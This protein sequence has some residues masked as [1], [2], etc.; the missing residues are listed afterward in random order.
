MPPLSA[1]G[2]T[3][4]M[5]AGEGGGC[6]RTKRSAPVRCGTFPQKPAVAR[7]VQYRRAVWQWAERGASFS[8]CL[9]LLTSLPFPALSCAK[10]WCSGDPSA[11][12]LLG[13]LLLLVAAL[14][15]G[16]A[17][18]EDYGRDA[19][20]EDAAPAGGSG[21]G[22]AGTMWI[23]N[24]KEVK[25]IL[26]PPN[27]IQCQCEEGVLACRDLEG[28]CACVGEALLCDG[29]YDC[30]QGEDEHHCNSG[31][32][33]PRGF[34]CPKTNK[35]IDK[36]LVCDSIDDCGDKSDER[37]CNLPKIN[38]NCS[39]D[40]QFT[41]AD[42]K[43]C[44]SKVWLCDG[45][46]DCQDKS[47]ETN[48]SS[49]C[50]PN[51]HSCGDGHCISSNW[52]CDGDPDCADESDELDCNKLTE[53]SCG[54]EQV[55]CAVEGRCLMQHYACDGENDCGDWSDEQNCGNET[56]LG[57]DFK[58]ESGRCIERKW[59]CDGAVDCLPDGEDEANCSLPLLE[60]GTAQ[61][62][63]CHPE[64]S[65]LCS[66]RCIPKEWWC[67][68]VK[69]C[70]DGSDEE[71]CNFTCP[72]E[73]FTC[74]PTACIPLQRRCDGHHD[75]LFGDDEKDCPQDSECPGLQCGS[76]ICNPAKHLCLCPP[77][78]TLAADNTTCEDVDECSVFRP[79]SQACENLPGSFNCS[80]I[81]GY[82]MLRPDHLTCKASQPPAY[83]IFS[84]R[85]E[86]RLISLNRSNY[87]SIAQGLQNAISIDYHYERRLI[88][89]SDVT[90]DVIM[91]AYMNGTGEKAI[92]RW[93]LRMPSGVSVDWINDHVYWLDGITMRI[94]VANLDGSSRRP[95]IWTNLQKPRGLLVHP[96][97]NL[98]I[99]TDWGSN[100]RIE[101]AFLDGSGR[102]VVIGEGLHWPNGITID[103]PTETLYWVD[104][105][106]HVIEAVHTDGSNRR[107]ILEGLRHPFAITIFEDTLYWTDWITR[108]I[109]KV[110]KR[111]GQGHSTLQGRLSF[112]MD[113]R[114]LHP[115]RQP[116]I[117]QSERHGC[118][119]RN[120]D[121]SHL[122]LSSRDSYSCYCPHGLI[123]L[124]DHR[125]CSERP[126]RTL[127]FAQRKN[128]RMISLQDILETNT[129]TSSLS[130]STNTS[131]MAQMRIDTVVP[132]NNVQAPVAL[133]PYTEEDMIFWTD[134]KAKTISR[135]HLNGS[136]HITVVRDGLEM[137]A[138]VAVDWVGH[139]LYWTD[140]GTSRIEVANLEGSMRC[141][142]IWRS[143][144]KPRD[145][146]VD[147]RAR[148]M[149]WTDW[150]KRAKI[151]RA[152]MDGE[153]RRVLVDTNLKWPNGLAIDHARQLLYWLDAS[154]KS[155]EM[156]ALDGSQR[157]ALISG[158]LE[159]PFGLALWRDLVFWTDWNA[160][161]MY[162]AD[163]RTGAN[164]QTI[165][166][167]LK[168][169]MEV[170]VFERSQPSSPNPC[171][172]ING[173]CSHLCLLSPFGLGRRCA[174]PTGIKLKPDRLN[175]YD[176]PE[177][178]LLFARR[179]D[180]RLVSLDTPYHVDVILPLQGLQHAVALDIDAM[181]GDI[182]LS[183][184]AAAIIFRVS[185]KGHLATPVVT[186]AILTVEGLAVDATG[187]KLYWTDL[188]MH[189]VEVSELDGSNR[190]VLFTGLRRP[191]AI[192]THY[193]SGRLFWTDWDEKYPTIEAADMDG[194]NRVVL[195]DTDVVWP[196]GLTVDWEDLELYWTDASTN[197]I[198]AIGL[199]G[200]N[201]RTVIAGLPH[202]Y[203]VSI[204]G[205]WLYWTDWET[206]SLNRTLKATGRST[207]TIREGL[208]GLMDVKALPGPPV[209]YDVCEENNGG[210]SHLCLRHPRGY[211]CACP[212]GLRMVEG[213]S[214][215]C[216]EEPDIYLIYAAKGTIGRISLD[217]KPLW[218]VPLPIPAV[219]RPISI[220]V[221]YEQNLLFYTEAN[222]QVI[223]VVSLKNM[224]YPWSILSPGYSTPNGLAVDWVA[225]NIYW[226]DSIRKVLEVARL[227]GSS[228]K[229][230]INNNLKSPRAIAVFPGEGLLFW[231]DWG[232][233]SKIERSYL[234]GSDRRSIIDRKSGWPNGLTIDYQMKRI[235]WNDAKVET[236]DSSDLNGENV[237]TL[238]REVPHPF[239]LTLLG[240]HIY[241]SNWEKTTIERADKTSG[242][243]RKM[244]RSRIEGIME[245]K[246]V[247]ANSQPG[248]NPCGD[249]NGGCTHL[250]FFL[251]SGRRCACPDILDGR[252]CSD[253]PMFKV[254]LTRKSG[255]VWSKGT[256]PPGIRPWDQDNAP[257]MVP[258]LGVL[259]LVLILS[260]LSMM[261]V[262][263]WWKFKRE[264][265][266]VNEPKGGALTYTN[267]TY[268]ASN[269]DVNTDRKP[270]TWRRL[271]SDN[272]HQ[273]R[274]FE[275]KGEVA[276]LISE[277]SSVEHESP[278]PTP[279]TRPEPAT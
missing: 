12:H 66:D 183:D 190:L 21:G 131:D 219:T 178:A 148:L 20:A 181:T 104:A 250:C 226:T 242:Q 200:Y 201:R 124:P 193:P 233:P 248:W 51:L 121:C 13:V 162:M 251:P 209:V 151:E 147:P 212:T 10:M 72:P 14:G 105:K 208:A 133:D 165:V 259:V 265:K 49:S 85:A 96:H 39:K 191:R 15:G 158:E 199:D 275:E 68:G 274:M 116:G 31:E 149:F 215:I 247:E 170:K 115:T 73:H 80:C 187:R 249:R 55:A 166:K 140:G 263:A 99:W 260:V 63:E 35:C 76:N 210:C 171:A 25:R 77:G 78:H 270:F 61:P 30:P 202:P 168:D 241:W 237:V 234:D 173:G 125:T 222:L 91:R 79:C 192:T 126:D 71:S 169:M 17:G 167:G 211:S 177:R 5:W 198:G 92:V 34:L 11:A 47:D 24:K 135:A 221:H 110:D 3:C 52:V 238:I 231:T 8:L 86:I 102:Q 74:S 22:A 56:C 127:I 188:H 18:K 42:G 16:V 69:D 182:F 261:A 2:I 268:S 27:D 26:R 189:S 65:R 269:S 88:Y 82:F 62:S 256:E 53:T 217:I 232:R 106:E 213:N 113:I 155:I 276:A 279:P 94:E 203:G 90:L 7:S 46:A 220:N 266:N 153:A 139:K 118:S 41:C 272:V 240:D 6:G 43:Y 36:S 4:W 19:D 83:L 245:V 59:V 111:N 230:V 75:C 142:L 29:R 117:L 119:L 108:S 229:V 146:V 122:C 81:A 136:R 214:S 112:P 48:C 243:N 176:G 109:E 156:A 33:C 273:V 32:A 160:K 67:D 258:L 89:W 134:I 70:S 196:N 138:G 98:L 204:L 114:S 45:D 277:G 161:S 54:P 175:C 179:E 206:K 38:A 84:N 271:H 97:K 57:N 278:P 254:N 186:A 123:L 101:R 197:V 145:I 227:D 144:D 120:G 216:M 235:F 50:Q 257:G 174:C 207:S 87:S 262:V 172:E 58:C 93:G 60:S 107:M 194:N 224:S 23:S 228:T 164:R 185:H 154:T 143:L 246:A 159:H 150:G 9:P 28:E 130:S 40:D 128:L 195:V 239:G 223:R 157:K 267:P 205:R 152:G 100:P 37:F 44:I 64:D 180:V 264:S 137:P 218:E 184:S 163:K 252:G 225:N 103:Y 253:R 244:V 132:V 141:L 1:P 129:S 95:L 255:G 236:I